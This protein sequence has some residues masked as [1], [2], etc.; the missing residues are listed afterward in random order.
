M[1]ADQVAEATNFIREVL[2]DA[3][4]GAYL[5]G[6]SVFGSLKPTSDLDLFV[7]T[8]R[9]TTDV[10]RRELI[11]RLLPMSG[12]GDPSGQSRSINIERRSTSRT[13]ATSSS[14][15]CRRRSTRC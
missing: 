14:R 15:T 5:H 11:E 13:L 7:V 2:A 9:R 6:S 10:Q 8:G 4:L 1:A 12:P 3:V